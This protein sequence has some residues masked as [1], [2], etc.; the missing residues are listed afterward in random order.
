[1]VLWLIKGIWG[2]IRDPARRFPILKGSF[3]EIR[4]QFIHVRESS[5][6]NLGGLRWLL[7]TDRDEVHLDPISNDDIS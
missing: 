7:A 1:M 3:G 6:R 4:R 5:I 2:V